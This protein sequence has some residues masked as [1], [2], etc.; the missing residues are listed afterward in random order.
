MRELDVEADG[1]PTGLLAAT[2]GRFHHARAAARDDREAVAREE[3]AGLACESVRGRLLPHARGPE[4]RHSGPVDLLHGLE[5]REELGGDQ[6]DV[7]RK[8]LVAA[9]QQAP[10]EFSRF[11]RRV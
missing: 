10:I 7:A 6:R 3:C 2:V 8:R 5:S 9:P 11:H 1:E 4:D